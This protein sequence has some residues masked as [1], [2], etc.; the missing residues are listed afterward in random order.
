MPEFFRYGWT[1][2][3]NMALGVF[4]SEPTDPQSGLAHGVNPYAQLPLLSRRGMCSSKS[5]AYMRI[6]RENCF[7]LLMQEI[8]RA[9]ARAWAKTGKRIAARMAIIAITTR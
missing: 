7:V 8:A 9:E 5:C 4:G 6:P 3:A 1:T 2:P